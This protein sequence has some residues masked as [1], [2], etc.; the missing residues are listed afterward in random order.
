LVRCK[1]FFFHN[2][3]SVYQQFREFFDYEEQNQSDD[4]EGMGDT[5][6]MGKKETTIRFYFN[7]TYQL[8]TEDITKMEQIDNLSLYLCL[9]ISALMKERFLK[10]KEEL[11]KLEKQTK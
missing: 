1:C 3:E 9:N 4:D 6:K 5:P 11:K 7:L 10:Q 8:A 2:R